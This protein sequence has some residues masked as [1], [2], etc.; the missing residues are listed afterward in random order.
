LTWPVEQIPNK[1]GFNSRSQ[2][3]AGVRR[4]HAGGQVQVPGAR[5]R[6]NLP[7]DLTSFVGRERENGGLP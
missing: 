7:A 4:T 6:G 2:I 1:V 5:L 3:A